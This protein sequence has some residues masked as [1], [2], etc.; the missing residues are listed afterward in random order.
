MVIRTFLGSIYRASHP[1]KTGSD[2]PVTFPNR[3]PKPQQGAGTA[4]KYRGMQ[5]CLHWTD[6]FNTV[7]LDYAKYEEQS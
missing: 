2:T 3:L 1:K 7:S 4:E 5:Q 6:H